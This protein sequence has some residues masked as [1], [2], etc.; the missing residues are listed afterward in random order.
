MSEIN[1]IRKSIFI[2]PNNQSRKSIRYTI[3]A[4]GEALMKTALGMELI[5]YLYNLK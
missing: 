2:S 1:P 5:C 4:Y 3:A